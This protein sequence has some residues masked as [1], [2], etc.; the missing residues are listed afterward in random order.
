M[1]DVVKTA[2]SCVGAF[3]DSIIAWVI[4]KLYG[5]IML[6]ADT[7]IFG[8]EVIGVFGKQLYVL[9]G[10][11]MLFSL[12]F[13]LVK[14]LINPSDFTS[15]E[16]GGSK[17]ITNIIVVLLLIV[18]IPTIFAQ[19]YHLQ[20][21]LLKNHV[22]DRIILGKGAPSSDTE[23]TSEGF[24]RQ[25]SFS[26]FSSFLIP[27]YS[28]VSS[29]NVCKQMYQKDA[30]DSVCENE[31]RNHMES[32]GV[33]K[34]KTAIEEQQI[35]HMLLSWSVLD[36]K[37]KVSGARI[38]AYQPFISAIVGI[39]VAFVLLG[40]AV[41][42]AIRSVKLGFL[43]LISPIPIISYV[44]PDPQKEGMLKNWTKTTI[45][46]YL[47]LFLRLA[48]LFFAVFV[49]SL[50]T[51]NN[52]ERISTGTPLNFAEH[53]FV[54]IFII[55]GTLLFAKQLPNLISE[56]TGIKLESAA[57]MGF[58]A[59][60]GIVGAGLGMATAGVGS[61][62]MAA[63]DK[64]DDED[65]TRGDIL[66]AGLGGLASGAGRGLFHGAKHS[67]KDGK[68]N[69]FGAAIGGGGAGVQAADA[70]RTRKELGIT[71]AE[72]YL[73]NPLRKWSGASDP[74]VKE[75]FGQSKGLER[76]LFTYDQQDQAY[77]MQYSQVV[78]QGVASGRNTA[79]DYEYATNTLEK[80]TRMADGTI[81]SEQVYDYD[82][83]KRWV[84]N[85]NVSRAPNEQIKIIDRAS[86]NQVAGVSS[87]KKTISDRRKLAEQ[88]LSKVE[89]ELKVRGSGSDNDK[90]GKKGG[91]GGK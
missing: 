74:K 66:K 13:S 84:R 19:A 25:L 49:I 50:L 11:F 56:L 32:D 41:D 4:D 42:I 90:K 15:K 62:A 9:I 6:I 54:K 18:S 47:D 57:G 3:I 60:A 59:G 65:A 88:Q 63:L 64:A 77:D 34:V 53:P 36:A 55:L 24:G 20:S 37:D 58:L 87:A 70:A 40:F 7:N 86:Y 61:A 91:L 31:L 12:S 38:F 71:N 69:P 48:A 8:S 17:I 33:K 30:L 76:D 51:S 43:Q 29:M 83:Y 35:S 16:K 78:S 5:L 14:F 85:E 2:L 23:E 82:L 72:H 80:Q 21:L 68:F 27:N 44:N 79:S 26:V 45:K 28:E 67:V 46:T 81:R 52:M 75:L 22:V 10:V 89:K 39:V 1:W 73:K